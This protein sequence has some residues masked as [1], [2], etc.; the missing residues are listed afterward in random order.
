MSLLTLPPLMAAED[1]DGPPIVTA[2]SWLIASADRGEVLASHLPDEPSKAASTTK[3]MCAFVV[4]KLAETHPA[5]LD[6]WITIS[7]L[8]DS[9]AGST[10]DLQAGEQV[11]VRDGLYALLLPSGNDMGNA[12]A[13]HFHPRLLPPG[14][15]TPTDAQTDASSTRRNF[16]AEMNRTA[17][18]L[19]MT[20]TVYRISYGDG[21][22]S[23]DRTTTARDLLTLARAAREIPLFREVV[24]CPKKIARIRLPDGSERE[25]V[26]QNTN[27]LLEL[28]GYDGIKTGTTPSA[29]RCL[30][31]SGT[32]AG[33]SLIVITL[34][35]TSDEGR[36]ADSRNLFRWA[37]QR[38]AKSAP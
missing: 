27:L 21:G 4:L 14:E 34:G 7:E 20:N 8:A 36:F 30:V 18:Q 10:A 12:F 2:R 32:H 37:W 24:A 31:A 16:V 6:E 38:L 29:G 26:W 35:S 1:L 5:V 22:T 9:T 13:E 15:E 33:H 19:G 11:Q 17:R 23:E 3:M 28:G 25:A